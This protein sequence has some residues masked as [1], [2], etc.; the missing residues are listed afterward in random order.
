[1]QSMP[2]MINASAARI[3]QSKVL[4]QFPAAS[5]QMS[6]KHPS[7]APAHGFSPKQ[8]FDR[9]ITSKHHNYSAQSPEKMKICDFDLNHY[10]ARHAIQKTL[11]C[12]LRFIS[13]DFL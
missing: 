11:P 9:E 5:R 2:S 13:A 6:A 10:N 8:A 1:M 3:V 12:R 7:P 4:A